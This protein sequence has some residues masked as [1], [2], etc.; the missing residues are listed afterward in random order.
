MSTTTISHVRN[1][2]DGSKLVQSNEEHTANVAALASEFAGKFGMA[3]WGGIIGLFHDL[4]KETREF[5]EYIKFETGLTTATP[6]NRHPQHSIYGAQ[7]CEKKYG[8]GAGILLGNVIAAH[9][10]GLKDTI[11]I[12]PVVHEQPPT[13]LSV[14]ASAPSIQPAGDWKEDE[15][16]MLVRMLLSCL[17]DAD[18][19][20]T[21]QFMNPDKNRLRGRVKTIPYLRKTLDVCLGGIQK[22]AADNEVNSVRRYVLERCRQMST[23]EQGFYSLTVPTGGGKTL[24]SLRWALGH[25]EEHGLE[26][27][28]IAIP[29]TSIIEQTASILKGIFGA[30]CVLEHHSQV[31]ESPD[32][33]TEMRASLATENWDAPIV[34]TTNVQLF[35]SLYSNMAS[36]C[37]KLHNIAKSVI[38]L[39]EVQ[40]LPLGFYAPI[41]TALK[42][43]ERKFGVSVLLTTAS[44]PILTGEWGRFGGK[45]KGIES[46]KEI[47][48]PSAELHRR[49]ARVELHNDNN[50]RDHESIA[51][52]LCRHD[53]VLCIVNTRRDAQEIFDRLPDD[54]VK[55]H[56]SRNMCP[57][58]I[59]KSLKRIKRLLAANS[60]EPI[61]IV[62]TQLIEAGV[63]IDLPVVYRQE[64]GLDS[65][66]QAAGRCN[67]EGKLEK[68][69][70]YVFRLGALPPGALSRG[71]A[72]RLNMRKCEDLFAP[73]AMTEYFTQLLSRCDDYDAKQIIKL[74][75]PNS[76]YFQAAAKEFRLIDE[77]TQPVFV[78]YGAADKLLD[79][80]RKNGMDRRLMRGMSQYMVSLRD[81]EIGQLLRFGLI[82]D[83]ALGFYRLTSPKNYHQDTGLTMENQYITEPLI[84]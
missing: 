74:L 35:E 24:S 11:D 73:A 52:E 44:Q 72:A 25:A 17:V 21:E 66:I 38:I 75:K 60:R 57:R 79:Y 41:I 16:N 31:T 63:D 62:S 33:E 58:H 27:V 69:H 18:R 9:H 20:D 28:I 51:K 70:T 64:A 45:F 59:K 10:S 36:Q 77:N 30:D 40:T 4:G 42:T 76:L 8:L 7:L 48:E 19:L 53:R 34:V 3:N 39:D 22:S 80:A 5:Q 50:R 61:R 46:I 67:R 1:L 49:L 47:I 55:I 29:Y 37:R 68:G 14:P 78:N 71:N 13:C 56:L 15:V 6:A 43:L 26:R 65:I 54:G 12:Q 84:I 81:R 82:E 32:A 2:P 83:T 23:R